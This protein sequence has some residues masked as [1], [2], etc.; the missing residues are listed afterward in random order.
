V[1]ILVAPLALVVIV[2]VVSYGWT[3]FRVGL[4][5]G[6]IVLAAVGVSALWPALRDRAG[7]L[8]GRR[9]APSA[10]SS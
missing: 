1:W 9:G 7:G 6:A 8:A 10:S 2:T 5:P 4:E 3:R